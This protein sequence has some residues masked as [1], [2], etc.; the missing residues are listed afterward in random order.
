MI[1]TP[2]FH[3]GRSLLCALLFLICS[4]LL[5]A[6][7]TARKPFN[8]PGEAA[9]AALK[10]LSRQ[11]DREVLF[12]SE[13]VAGIRTNEVK[14]EFTPL[15]AA[16]RMLAR[17]GLVAVQDGKTGA[18]LINRGPAPSAP[19]SPPAAP[20]R[21]AEKD[22]SA[23]RA[24]GAADPEVLQLSP[25][26]VNSKT[27]RGYIATRAIGATKTNTPMIE[28]PHSIQVLN[29]EFIE[30]TGAVTVYD[31]VRFTS[32]ASGVDQRNDDTILLRGFGATR[33]RNGLAY[34]SSENFTF[35]DTFAFERV[36]VIKGASAV[37]YGVSA[38]GGL[39]NMIDKAPSPKRAGQLRVEA[40][41]Y[42]FFK[43]AL[44]LTGPLLPQDDNYAVNYRLI[45][46]H[47]NSKSW[48]WFAERERTY[49]NAAVSARLHRNTTL[50]VRF[51]LQDDYVNAS[52][53]KPYM[54]VTNAAARQY[55]LLDLPDAFHRGEPSDYR[56]VTRFNSLVT[57]NHAFND[58]WNLQASLVSNDHYA[59]REETFISAQGPS[60]NSWPRQMSW[61]IDDQQQLTGEALLLGALDA[62]WSTH[63]LL[64]GYNYFNNVRD[65][66]IT[67]YGRTNLDVFNPVY[68][69]PLLG[70]LTNFRRHT[71][72]ETTA[73]GAFIQNH[74]ALFQGRLNFI[75]G[76]RKDV[77]E[78]NVL[79]RINN[80]RTLQEDDQ[81]SPR[82]GILW[83]IRPEWSLY[84]SYNESFQP[85]PGSQ[86]FAGVPFPSPTAEQTEIGVK[87][88]LLSGKVTGG[89]AAFENI[90]RNQTTVDPLNPGFSIATGE[91]TSEGFEIDLGLEVT[92]NWQILAAAGVQKAEITADTNPAR[93]GLEFDNVPNFTCSFW[94]KYDF[95]AGT[96]DGLSLGLGLVREA[97]RNLTESGIILVIPDFTIFNALV[98]YRRGD[99]RIA[100]NAENVFDKS[101]ITRSSGGRAVAPGEHRTIRLTYTRS[102]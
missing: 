95:K 46:T 64:V 99:N 89:L 10:N 25:F 101:Y 62:G 29:K 88:N 65:N 87:F 15:E 37:L 98:S 80:T 24:D 51:E 67:R 91:I 13:V 54:Y 102:F 7:D 38:P 68:R 35:E 52:Y 17:T 79:N 20:A 8:L 97:N 81:V 94:T 5:L 100:L 30:D 69:T 21:P 22:D 42:D 84:A 2:M 16:D 90:R 43:L 26:A 56:D 70:E 86:S 53:F 58:R 49:L 85:A 44:D 41:S 28:L 83:R 77:L 74:M 6:A 78:Q 34:P 14:G 93:V 27:D 12:A 73:H 45:G 31:I 76:I 4:S 11:S 3:R 57:L 9:E 47:E 60:L 23:A 63:Q 40:A 75:A 82:Y 18:L 33:L 1:I 50:T 36:E 59:K 61:V 48:R 71:D 92:P 66:Y 32:N 72:T 39:I 55:V 19:A 96:L